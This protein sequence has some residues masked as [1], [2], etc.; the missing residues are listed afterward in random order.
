MRLSEWRAVA[1]ARPSVDPKV[2]PSSSRCSR[3]SA[4]ARDP[5][6]WVVWGDDVTSRWQVLVPHAARASWWCSSASTWPARVRAPRRSSS[7]GRGS[8]WASSRS[9]RRAATGSCRSRWR[10]RSSRASMPKP[11]G[12]PRS[13][14][15]CCSAIDGRVDG[16]RRRRSARSSPRGRHGGALAR[17][18]APQS[19][20]RSSSAPAEPRQTAD[21]EGGCGERCGEA[22]RAAREVKA[23]PGEDAARVRRRAPGPGAGARLPASAGPPRSQPAPRPRP[24]ERRSACAS[25]RSVAAHRPR[26]AR[27]LDPCATLNDTWWRRFARL[28][29]GPTRGPDRGSPTASRGRRSCTASTT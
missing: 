21:G 16:R 11:T 2:S 25:V 10:T 5:H 9:R 3:R 15:G 13:R 14:S 23:D 24:P 4:P 22:A 27:R 7:A 8:R 6:C 1:P 12:W 19:G 18:K 29:V 28:V 20:G 17:A 26:R